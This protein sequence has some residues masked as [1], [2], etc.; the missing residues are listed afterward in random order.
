MD[1][2]TL[3]LSVLAILAAACGIDSTATAVVGDDVV[4]NG[5]TKQKEVWSN[6]DA[7]TLF[8]SNLEYRLEALPMTGEAT[9]IPWAGSYWPTY[10][11]NI[12]FKWAGP[13]SMSASK[14]YER[15]F[16]P[17]GGVNVENL[18]SRYHGIDSVAKT[19]QQESECSSEFGEVCARRE[20]ADAGHCIATWWGICHAWSPAA[21]LLPEPRYP[22]TRNDITFQPQDLKALGSLVHNNTTSKFVSLRCNKQNTLADGGGIAYDELGRPTD[23]NRECRDT[24]AGT[25]H[26][27]ITNYLGIMKQAFVEDRTFNYE[28]WNQPLRGFTVTSKT[29]VNANEANRLIGASASPG[30]DAGVVY[31]FNPNAK[32]FFDVKMQVKYISESGADDGYTAPNIN[33]YTHTDSYEYVLELDA[34][35]KIIGGEWVGASKQAHP[36]FLWLPTGPGGTSVA[37]GAIKYAQVRELVFESAG[38]LS[39]GGQP[40]PGALQDSTVQ[41]TLAQ[42]EWKHFGPFPTAA[43]GITVEMTGT[44]DADLYVRLGG[45][46]TEALYDCRPYSDGSAESC[47]LTGPGPLYVSVHGYAASSVSVRIRYTAS[48]GVTPPPVVVVDA[49]T[50]PPPPG[51][52][53]IPADE[54]FTGTVA[55]GAWKHFGPWSAGTGT[56]Q[57]DMTGTG[58]GDLYVRKGSAPTDTAYDRRPY[59]S[60]SAESCSLTLSAPGLVYVSVKGYSAATVSVRVRFTGGAAPAPATHLDVS[61]SVALNEVKVFQVPVTAGK[62]I[63]VRTTAPNDVDLYV[64]LGA[65]PTT[66]A[67]DARGYTGSGNETVSFTPTSSGTLFIGVHGY[68]ASSFTLKTADQ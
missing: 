16:I 35:G 59:K 14:K 6:A 53:T 55:A 51:P 40:P 48:G 64:K 2:R 52:G 11:D 58:D 36:D 42:G 34:A 62:K 49:G 50:P 8:T 68:A 5:S 20:G 4:S 1:T 10:E 47:T 12:N 17:D 39:D 63:V 26:L 41:A 28:V 22:V 23:A 46:P 33:L 19:C 18:V 30:N 31:R 44:G 25:Y 61:G 38:L 7:P 3:K 65:A 37:G 54:S 13:G 66:A 9:T 32:R 15:A 56:V 29:E 67:Y 57:I 45:Q 24:N 43:G 27:L 60:G 21:I